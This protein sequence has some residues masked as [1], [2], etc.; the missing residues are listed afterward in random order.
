MSD[1]VFLRAW[2]PVEPKKYYN[3]LTT[4]LESDPLEWKGMKSIYQIRNEKGIPIPVK[5]DSNYRVRIILFFFLVF[6]KSS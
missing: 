5:P 4:F 6:F 3:P 1:I 2:V